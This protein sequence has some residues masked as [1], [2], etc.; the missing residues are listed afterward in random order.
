MRKNG[1][2]GLLAFLAIASVASTAGAWAQARDERWY[3]GAS[4]GR[5]EFIDQCEGVSVSCKDTDTAFRIFGGYRFHRNFAAELGYANLGKAKA[6]GTI[7]GV[8][9]R[10][11]L[12]AQTWDLV[13]VGMLPVAQNISLLGKLGMHR[14]EAK[15]SATGSV[16]GF[17]A[18]TSS[19]ETNTDLTFG[20]GAQYD[21]SRNFAA[22]AEWQR[23]K[24]LGGDDI[25]G[26]FDIDVISIAGLFKF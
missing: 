4:I 18:S 5:S 23:Y 16:A 17:S 7:S 24:K 13:G 26:K 15:V 2:K 3:A 14:S 12:K 10:A 20:L 25:G 11:D 8:S 22:R 1:K 6:D 21:F 19:K 9:V